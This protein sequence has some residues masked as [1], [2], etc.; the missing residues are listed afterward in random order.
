MDFKTFLMLFLVVMLFAGLFFIYKSV[1]GWDRDYIPKK[2]KTKIIRQILGY[3]G[4]R[5][6]MG[7]IGVLFLILPLYTFSDKFLGI[8]LNKRI[9]DKQDFIVLSS[10]ADPVKTPESITTPSGE[11]TGTLSVMADHINYSSEKVLNSYYKIVLKDNYLEELPP[12]V[13]KLKNLEEI[14]LENNDLKDL[15]VE[16]LLELK[17]LKKL[18]LKNNP[19]SKE[20]SEKLK[21]LNKIEISK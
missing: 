17:N 10:K 16:K 21:S 18:N 9:T 7:T 12:F 1:K 13:W 3:N 19:L 2:M 14:D 8:H 5:L 6:L 15:P 11:R 4:S 20:S